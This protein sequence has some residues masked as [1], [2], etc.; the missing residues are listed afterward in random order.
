MNI[1]SF[2][3]TTPLSRGLIAS[4]R[5]DGETEAVVARQFGIDRKT[6]R[7]WSVRKREEGVV[8]LQDR[9]SR[10]KVSSSSEAPP[11]TN[12]GAARASSPNPSSP[13]S[14]VDLV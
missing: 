9:S 10:P 14:T 12:H 4:R 6:V 1:H 2:A 7:K 5:A 8:G 3:R 11:S 13:R